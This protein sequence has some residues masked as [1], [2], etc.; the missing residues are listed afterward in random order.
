MSDPTDAHSLPNASS[1]AAATTS[2]SS[3]LLNG[4]AGQNSDAFRQEWDIGVSDVPGN[5]T[6]SGGCDETS[7]EA[8]RVPPQPLPPPSQP[9]QG[10]SLGPV[11]A[12]SG[13]TSI[14]VRGGVHGGG[15]GDLVGGSG[16]RGG[17]TQPLDLDALGMWWSDSEGSLSEDDDDDDDGIGGGRSRGSGSWQSTCPCLPVSLGRGL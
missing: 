6:S 2:G 15:H 7:A 17:G 14:G 3:G 5:L 10:A 9:V 12:H 8:P 1:A 13:P 4:A 11:D 16:S